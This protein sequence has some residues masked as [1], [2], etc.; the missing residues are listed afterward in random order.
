MPHPSLLTESQ[1]HKE[2]EATVFCGE[3]DPLNWVYLP[4]DSLS[5]VFL[6]GLGA[7]LYSWKTIPFL[8]KSAIVF[9]CLQ[10]QASS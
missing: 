7:T 10:S 3:R 4:M 1:R 6:K 5:P 9:F 8:C 2:E